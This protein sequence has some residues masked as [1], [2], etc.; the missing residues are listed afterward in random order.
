MA[1]T[2]ELLTLA[3]L[4]ARPPVAAWVDITP[5]TNATASYNQMSNTWPVDAYDPAVGTTYR[6]TVRGAGT[7]GSTQQ[8]IGHQ[9]N[10][11]G[12]ATIANRVM[13]AATIGSSDVFSWLYA[14]E[15]TVLT[16]GA[17]GTARVSSDFTWTQGTGGSGI[18]AT[19][20][21]TAITEATASINTTVNGNVALQ[22]AWGSATGGPTLTS[23]RS[24]FERIGP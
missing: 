4:A 5:Y 23:Y 16:I 2:I 20:S 12:A 8:A 14:V 18:T 7:Q 21:V 17:T 1:S 11:L 15:I 13:A 6:L 9:V 19:N 3:K 22:M 10:C 24:V